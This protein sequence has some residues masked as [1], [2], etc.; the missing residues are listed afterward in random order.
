MST[1]RQITN[2]VAIAGQ[3]TLDDLQQ[4][5]E[6]GYRTIVNLRSPY[7]PGFL[8]DEQA[9]V[10]R[11]SLTYISMP[12][13]AAN[14]SCDNILPVIQQL[15][16]LPKPMLIHC[17]NGIRASVIVLMQIAIEQGINAEAAFQKVKELGLLS[18]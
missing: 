14:L 6:A 4:L 10:E 7:E 8:E 1:V 15:L 11:L 5:L 13:Q 12:I 2:E 9:K 17:D 3:V 16:A 18:D